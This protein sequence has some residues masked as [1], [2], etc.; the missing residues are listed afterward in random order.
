LETSR[1]YSAKNMT[2]LLMALNST[3][4]KGGV[5]HYHRSP[6]HHFDIAE[7][8]WKNRD[9]Q[10]SIQL[11]EIADNRVR[12]QEFRTFAKRDM[13]REKPSSLTNFKFVLDNKLKNQNNLEKI[14]KFDDEFVPSHHNHSASVIGDAW[15]IRSGRKDAVNRS[16]LSKYRSNF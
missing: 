14:N 1:E 10:D 9:E 4:E 16:N 7:E 5:I 13:Q 2:E 12:P 3:P 6:P 11:S 15:T 8:S